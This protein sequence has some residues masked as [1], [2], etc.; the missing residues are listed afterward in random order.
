MIVLKDEP[1]PRHV[2]A[3]LIEAIT[4]VANGNAAGAVYELASIEG[5]VLFDGDQDFKEY[6]DGLQRSK[7]G[8]TP[9]A[10]EQEEE[11]QEEELGVP[12]G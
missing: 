1:E 3:H 5:L 11:D 2:I 12:R 8:V 7:Q 6:I 9:E 10:A 4:A